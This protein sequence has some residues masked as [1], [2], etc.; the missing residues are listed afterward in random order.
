MDDIQRIL[1][2]SRWTKDCKKA[3]HHGI[4]LARSYRA[5]LS[6][7]HIIGGMFELTGGLLYASRLAD[8]EAG[9]KAEVEEVKRDF[10]AMIEA[11]HAKGMAIKETIR[12]GKPAAEIFKAVEEGKIDLLIMAHHEEDRLEHYLFCRD[13]EKVLRRM[14]CSVMLVK[15]EPWKEMDKKASRRGKSYPL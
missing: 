2:V 12:D 8:L 4:S 15:T 5:E 3:L 9:Y 13:Y 6:I 11:E 14:P 7:L 10:D 1:V